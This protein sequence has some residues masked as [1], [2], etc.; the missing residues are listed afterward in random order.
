LDD[1]QFLDRHFLGG[2]VTFSGDVHPFSG[3]PGPLGKDDL[4]FKACGGQGTGNQCANGS[5][6]V[7]AAASPQSSAAFSSR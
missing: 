3:N 6:V 1:G 4:G 2:A 7:A 5:G